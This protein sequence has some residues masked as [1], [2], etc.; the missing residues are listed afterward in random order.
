[1]LNIIMKQNFMNVSVLSINEIVKP[2]DYYSDKTNDALTDLV[3]LTDYLSKSYLRKQS[4][5]YNVFVGINSVKEIKKYF[6]YLNESHI[7]YQIDEITWDEKSLDSLIHSQSTQ[8]LTKLRF[9]DFIAF[10]DFMNITNSRIPNGISLLHIYQNIKKLV[11]IFDSI[12]EFDLTSGMDS[13]QH[14][15]NL[16]EVWLEGSLYGDREINGLREDTFLRLL[17]KTI[18]SLTILNFSTDIQKMENKLGSLFPDLKSIS[19]GDR[20]Y[21]WLSF[22]ENYLL[23]FK[24]LQ[25]VTFQCPLEHDYIIPS[26][27]RVFV[28]TECERFT[29]NLKSLNKNEFAENVEIEKACD[30]CYHR[31][32]FKNSVKYTSTD[33]TNGTI[34]YKSYNDLNLFLRNNPTVAF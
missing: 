20:H 6:D 23:E 27:L 30:C 11:L 25:M 21:Q 22:N 5:I 28:I 32:P 29:V 14:L 9:M 33:D 17:P 4:K 1:M 13:F 34:Y 24:D 2:C 10:N 7:K 26:T 8:Y 16:K 3:E 18:E 31:R 12:Q 19:F 15:L